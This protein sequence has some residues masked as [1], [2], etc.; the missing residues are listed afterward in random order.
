MK[1]S[2]WTHSFQVKLLMIGCFVSQEEGTNL[3]F[4]R[5]RKISLHCVL[6]VEVW[7]VWVELL[8]KIDYLHFPSFL[9]PLLWSIWAAHPLNINS[10]NT[11][12]QAVEGPTSWMSGCQGFYE[13]I[14]NLEIG[15]SRVWYMIYCEFKYHRTQITK[16]ITYSLAAKPPQGSFKVT[17]SL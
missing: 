10:W 7:G 16:G 14:Q 17:W 4:C 8:Q 13:T 3:M 6:H 12:A 11:K 9:F 2:A 1:A 5:F 15:W